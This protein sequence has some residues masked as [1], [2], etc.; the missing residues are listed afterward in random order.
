M[1]GWVVSSGY[2]KELEKGWVDARMNV[3]VLVCDRVVVNGKKG[4]GWMD[5][6]MHGWVGGEEVVNG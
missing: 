3:W 4:S 2:R 5:R 6:W 1:S